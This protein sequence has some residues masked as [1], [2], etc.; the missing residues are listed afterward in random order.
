MLFVRYI[1]LYQYPVADSFRLLFE[2]KKSIPHSKSLVR[3]IYIFFFVNTNVLI[4]TLGKSFRAP[5]PSLT[6]EAA[7]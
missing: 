5:L 3:Y 4:K 6:S 7:K 2:R 1:Y